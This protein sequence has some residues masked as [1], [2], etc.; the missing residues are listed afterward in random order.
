MN[1]FDKVQYEANYGEGSA[2]FTKDIKAVNIFNKI[3]W[4]GTEINPAE[5]DSQYGYWGLPTGTQVIKYTLKDPTT[6]PEG[7]FL[8]RSFGGGGDIKLEA[9]KSTKT[10]GQQSAVIKVEIPNSVTTIE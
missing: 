1:Y 2:P 10:F 5:L 3:E 4:N 6:I 9:L 7:L 8:L